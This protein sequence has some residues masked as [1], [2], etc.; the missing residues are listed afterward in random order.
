MFQSPIIVESLPQLQQVCV[1]HCE[2]WSFHTAT[3]SSDT[4]KLEFHR[5]HTL[6]VLST[7]TVSGLL[8]YRVHAVLPFQCTDTLWLAFPVL[9]ASL[10]SQTVGVTISKLNYRQNFTVLFERSL[11]TPRETIA[12]I[13]MRG[14][15]LSVQLS[16]S[17]KHL[18]QH[19][20]SST[21]VLFVKTFER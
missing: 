13:A 1:C 6:C 12:S 19:I 3:T 10:S 8:Y 5:A 18:W 7:V 20:K 4:T 21:C 14:I 15:V 9:S 2:V 17:S 16:R 11:K